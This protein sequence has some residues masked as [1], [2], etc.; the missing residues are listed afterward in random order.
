VTTSLPPCDNWIIHVAVEQCREG[1]VRVV[2]PTSHSDAGYF[3]ELLGGLL[4]G[5]R[6]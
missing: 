3:G 6:G 2:A 5:A 1:D 4:A